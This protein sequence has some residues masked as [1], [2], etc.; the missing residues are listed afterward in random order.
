MKKSL[1]P[2]LTF[3]FVSISLILSAQQTVFYPT[4]VVQAVYA[5]VTPPLRDMKL[6]P[7]VRDENAPEKEIKNKIGMKEFNHFI[8]PPFN[9]PEDPVWQKQDGTFLPLAP[10]Q[11]FDGMNNILG[12]YPPDTQG[13]VGPDKYF[14]VV[15]CNFAIYSKTGS[16]LLGPAL[17]SSIWSGIPAPYNGTNDGDPVVLYDQ[18]AQRWIISEFSLPSTSQNAELVA[19][20]Q[21]SDPTGAWYRYVFEFGNKMPDYPKFGVWPDGYYL[22]FNQFVNQSY[23][24]GVGACALQRSKMLTGD[25]TAQMVYFDLG[26]SSNPSNMLPSDWDGT[27]P[28]QTNEPNYFTFFDDWSST[29]NDYLKIWSFHVD[30]TTTANSTFTET[31]SLITSPFDSEICTAT[32]GRCIPQ[33]GTTV[34]LESLS[35]RLMYRLQYRNF[36][37]HRSMVTNHTVDVDGTGHAGIR[38]YELRNTGSSWT[39]YQQGTYSPDA[40]HRWVGSVAMNANGDIALGYSVSASTS[41][42]PSIR[43][44]GR[45]ASDPLGQMTVVE[46]NI[47]TGTGSQ[48]GSYARWGDYSM[49]SVDPTDDQTFWFTTEY[50]Q[51][52]GATSW[53]TR[54]ASFKFANTPTVITQ[55]A[56]S[57]TSSSAVLNGTINPNGL[58]STYH[59]EYGP[60]T[61]Y[62]SN[63]AVLSAGAGTSSIAVNASIS[64]LTSGVTYHYRLVG[65]NSDGTSNGSDMT[66]T[67]GAAA[68][69]TT[70]A[71]N[72]TA[73]TAT[74]GGNV[75]TD[76]GSSVT[77][78]GT[79]WN[80]TA[81]PTVSGNHTTDGAGLGSFVSSLTGLAP[82]TTYHIRAYATNG[83]G[84][85]Y[86]EDLQFTSSCGIITALPFNEGFE[87]SS[88][89]P[90]CWSEENSN[91]AWQFIKGNGGSNPANA[92]TGVRN[93]CLKD[94][95]SAANLNKLITPVFD[96]TGYTNVQLSFWIYMQAWSGDQDELKV[97]YR[98]SSSGSWN[99]LSTYNTSV[100]TWTQ[101]T[102]ALTSLSAEFQIAFEGNAKYGY[103]VCV[104][105][106]QITG[107]P[108]VTLSVS[109][110]NQNVT[111]PAGTTNFSVICPIAWTAVSNSTSWCTVTP[112]GTGN[113]TIVATY[114]ENTSISSR[115]ATITVSASGAP[116]QTVTVTQEGATP[117]LSVTPQNQNVTA[118]AGSTD[119]TVTSNTD[120]TVSSNASW[121]TPTL[122]G[123][124]NGTILANY[125]ENTSFDPRVATLTVTI[126]GLS[127]SVTVTQEGA[128]PTLAVQPSNQDVSAPAGFT[129]FNVSS[130]TSW[131]VTSNVSWCVPTASGTGNGVIDAV[132]EENTSTA[133]RTAIL[134]VTVS[135]LSPV[136]VTVTQSGAAPILAVQPSNQDVPFSAGSTN[137]SVTSNTVWSAISDAPWCIVTSSGSGS[138]T[139]MANYT[140]N[141]SNIQRIAHI[142]VSVNG[143]SPVTVTVTQAPLVSVEELT[144][145]GIRIYPNPARGVFRV[146]IDQGW[147]QIME[148]SVVD[149]TGKTIAS[150]INQGEKEYEFDLSSSPQGAYMIKIKTENSI[151]TRKLV[152]SK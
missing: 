126:S 68:V 150:K 94:N 43:Y 111:P 85:F 34:K 136:T 92:H 79:C 16:V 144:E 40:S 147:K 133:T 91:P 138:G 109:P 22:S 86:G 13:D 121:C 84:T 4:K 78:R 56:T 1:L 127:Q 65:E 11:N 116:N 141:P 77:A 69:T 48:T 12:Y 120:W 128:L 17:L 71:S 45:R 32:R 63:T 25:V 6:I 93:A 2:I 149:Y 53:K 26:A 28:P 60:S 23:W 59:F 9:L 44:T 36:G 148:I 118:P 97:Y 108:G 39:I 15:N 18:A 103:G 8:T 124:G 146:V 37:S 100:T 95:S 72:I 52:T 61:S 106:I 83:N 70:A 134:T 89:R 5:D 90:S 145:D 129:T 122:T 81:N 117:T 42:Y 10:I 76:G 131:T 135:G 66:F 46:Q 114:A 14:Q 35:D 74:A 3:V 67:P 80:T 38:W 58:A 107:T 96:L 64:A 99:L 30:W 50:V 24:G 47:I 51:T 55:D 82:T 119:F 88:L 104:D 151:L 143:L 110:S 33:P 87:S 125:T 137:F 27:T 130:N 98:T 41:V 54:I 75:I 140:A 132:Y 57:V 21:T 20:S 62:G 115:V 139:L 142:Q 152:I 102:L 49:M 29:T 31:A 7:V 105:D 123:S 101:K 112:S 19:I 113:G 73:T